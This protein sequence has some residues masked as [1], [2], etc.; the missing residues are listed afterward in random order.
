MK[1]GRMRWVVHLASMGEMGNI[2]KIVIVV[3]EK[4]RPFE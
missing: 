3:P 2:P 4:N 1:S